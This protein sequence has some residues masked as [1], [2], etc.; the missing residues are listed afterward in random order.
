MWD[1]V[2]AVSFIRKLALPLE[3]QGWGVALAGSVLKK[4]FSRHDLDVVVFPRSTEDVDVDLVYAVLKQAGMARKYDVETVHAAWRRKGSLDTKHV[5]VWE[6]AMLERV[7]I[8][9]LR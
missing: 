8:F 2:E 9:F 3:R 1:L 5:E 7:D 4:G 6:T